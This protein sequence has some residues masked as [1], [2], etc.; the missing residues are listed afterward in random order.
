MNKKLLHLPANT[1]GRDFVVG[2]LHA[3]FDDLQYVLSK[4]LNFD[5]TKDRLISVGDLIDRGPASMECAGLLYEPWFFSVR[6][7]HEQ[8]MIDAILHKDKD[9]EATWFW[10]GG[11][12]AKDYH[13]TELRIAAEKMDT[14]PL[15]I[16]VGDGPD[17]FNVVHADLVKKV[18]QML[19]GVHAGVPIP[20]TDKIIDRWQF[21][22]N[23][24]EDFIWGRS[25]IA[26]VPDYLWHDENF[27]SLTFVGHTPQREVKRAQQQ[28]YLDLGGVYHH[29][30]TN[31]SEQNGLAFACPAEK[32]VYVYNMMWKTITVIPFDEITRVK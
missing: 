22:A 16:T 29:T 8:M 13:D 32:V 4:G 3:C 31:K 21:S 23:D 30:S 5:P 24:E 18:P 25:V 27:M 19:Y 9:M 11:Q 6:G 2:D 17:R 28:I 14:L 10:N 7:N 1:A 15:I 20:V 12:W 26:P